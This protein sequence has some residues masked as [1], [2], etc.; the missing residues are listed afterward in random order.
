M[1]ASDSKAEYSLTDSAESGSHVCQSK[2]PT[3]CEGLERMRQ[4][5]TLRIVVICARSRWGGPPAQRPV[6]CGAVQA[7]CRVGAV[8]AGGSGGQ[9]RQHA[10]RG[11]SLRCWSCGLGGHGDQRAARGTSLSRWRAKARCSNGCVRPR[12]LPHAPPVAPWLGI[13]GGST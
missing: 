10:A 3:L 6:L 1:R 7:M 5:T 11:T 12:T 8:Q 4:P 2:G 13:E 9:H